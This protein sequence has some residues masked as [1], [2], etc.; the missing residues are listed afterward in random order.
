MDSARSDA[1]QEILGRELGVP[2]DAWRRSPHGKPELVGFPAQV[3]LSHDGDFTLVAV[4]ENRPVGVD[5][6]RSVPAA[7]AVR[8]AARF[9][10]ADEARYVASATTPAEQ[11]D[12]YTIL[13]TRK[14]ACVKAAGGRLLP[15]LRLPVR[16]NDNVVVRDGRR[17]YR[18]R[19][20]SMPTG[21]HAAV[22]VSGSAPYHLESHDWAVCHGHA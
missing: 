21:Y 22:A 16:G 12:R 13:W 10:P 7:Q 20:I 19:N 6:Q 9:Y 8:L 5:V 3:N 1:A 11:A 17:T 2:A 4:I 15:G 14:E 18:V